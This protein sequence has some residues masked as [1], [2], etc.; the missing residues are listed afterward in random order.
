MSDEAAEILALKA[1]AFI[2]QN[3][4]LRDRFMALSGIDEGMIKN[5]VQDKVFLASVLEF[6]VNFEPDLIV[7]AESED[8]SPDVVINAWRSLGGG[9]GQDW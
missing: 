1:V 9:A 2:I 3:D 8:I 5:A 4:E 6:F 7:F